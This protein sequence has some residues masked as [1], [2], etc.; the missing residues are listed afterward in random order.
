[1]VVIAITYL[2]LIVGEL[3]PKQV[4]LRDPERIATRVAPIMASIASVAAP[5]VWLLDV[6]AKLVLRLIGQSG[7]LEERV[8]DEEVRSIIAEA[9]SAGALETEERHLNSGVM[10]LADRSARGLKTLG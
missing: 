8:T 10:R 5:V 6:S 3:V 4:A 2:S 1:I 7:T 9:E